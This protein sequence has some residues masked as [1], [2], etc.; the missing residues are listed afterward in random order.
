MLVDSRVADTECLGCFRVR[1]LFVVVECEDAPVLLRKLA[2][3]YLLEGSHQFFVLQIHPGIL[4]L[5]QFF[6]HLALQ[7]ALSEEVQALVAGDSE[8]IAGHGIVCHFG[9]LLP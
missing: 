7:L 5:C 4:S 6:L 2:V 8:Q 3:D 1:E 9:L